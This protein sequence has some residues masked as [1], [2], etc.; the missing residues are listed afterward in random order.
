MSSTGGVLCSAHTQEDINHAT[1]AFD[2]TIAALLEQELI[3][4]L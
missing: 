3:Y 4:T 1:K 2:Q